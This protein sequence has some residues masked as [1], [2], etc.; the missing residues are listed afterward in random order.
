MQEILES[1][2][3]RVAAVFTGGSP[4]MELPEYYKEAFGERQQSFVSPWFLTL[5]NRKGIYI[6]R[7]LVMNLFRAAD[8]LKEIRHLRKRIA[9]L[10]P[11]VVV[12]FYEVIGALAMRKL[13][14][15]IRRI[16]V[17]HH[18]LLHL[19]NYPCGRRN[20]L[21]EAL[22]KIHTRMILASC[23]RLLALS[24]RELPGKGKI[25]VVPP[26]VRKIFRE[27]TWEQG[28]SYLVYLLQEGFIG[29]LIRLAR[30]DPRFS[31]DL[32][33]S[34]PVE[35]EV[36]PGIRLHSV[37]EHAFREKMLTCRALLG[38]AG[39]DTLAEAASLGIPAGVVPA[40][41]HFE[42]QCNAAD[43]ERSGLGVWLRG[44]TAG[45]LERIAGDPGREYRMWLDSAAET[46]LKEIKG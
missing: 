36:P 33:S 43:L 46:V 37:S 2:G 28:S 19:E 44:F 6:G 31:C 10:Q 17:G 5:P 40:E 7:T 29:E 45:E 32:F 42:Q 18:F 24:F 13:P 27:G 4:A 3:D 34:L 39:F 14:P 25:A 15:H 20:R 9:G 16:G 23:D 22:L 35:A 21:Q 38:T 26:L 30:E 41:N 12:N 11:D 8:Y 1:A